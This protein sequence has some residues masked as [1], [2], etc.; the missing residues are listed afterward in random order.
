MGFAHHVNK[1]CAYKKCR[2]WTCSRESEAS[3]F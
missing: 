1:L 3:V 2:R